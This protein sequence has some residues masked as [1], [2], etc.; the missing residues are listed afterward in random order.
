[1]A[2]LLPNLTSSDNR[3]RSIVPQSLLIKLFNRLDIIREISSPEVILIILYKKE[4]YANYSFVNITYYTVFLEIISI[5]K[6][7]VLP[8]TRDEVLEAG[9]TSI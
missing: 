3:P 8:D 9:D 1:M 4:R 6:N 7:E 5:L 2:D